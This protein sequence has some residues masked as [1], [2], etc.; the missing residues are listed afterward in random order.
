MIAE[1]TWEKEIVLSLFHYQLLV[2]LICNKRPNTVPKP[3]W[4]AGSIISETGLK[5]KMCGDECP[6]GETLERGVVWF[7][8][9]TW[10]DK[11]KRLLG[12]CML[13]TWMP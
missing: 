6:R 5:G 4:L 11:K 2:P 1:R 3:C 8:W 7:S 10:V 13:L 9:T 12:N